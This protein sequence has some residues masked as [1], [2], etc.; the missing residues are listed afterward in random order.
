MR[1][2]ERKLASAMTSLWLD[3]PFFASLTARLPLKA[4]PS[5]TDTMATDAAYIYYAPRFVEDADEAELAGVLAHEGLHVGNGHCHRRN[6]REQELWGEACDYA[7]NALLR[8]AGV[9]LPADGLHDP[10]FEGMAAEEIYRALRDR[11]MQEQEQQQQ[12]DEQQ[13]SQQESNDAGQ[14]A[15]PPGGDDDGAEGD[16]QSDADVAGGGAGDDAEGG[17]DGADQGDAQGKGEGE[18][19]GEGEGEGAGEG[20][21]LSAAPRHTGRAGGVLDAT[22]DA[23]S[24]GECVEALAMAAVVTQGRGKMPAGAD[25][26]LAEA[27]RARMDW[28]AETRRFLTTLRPTDYAWARPNAR[29]AAQRLYLPGLREQR[30]GHL[31]LAVDTSGSTG[32]WWAQFIAEVAQIVNELQPDRVTLLQCD[33]AVSDVRT[34]ERGEELSADGFAIKGGGGTSFVPIFEYVERETLLP[35]A[36]ILLTDTDGDW[37]EREPEYPV[38]VASVSASGTAPFGEVIY[39][40]G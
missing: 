39:M 33:A 17:G 16:G 32:Y 13:D 2:A 34:F 1:T 14:S 5:V 31:V 10:E 15:E 9:R 11:R 26:M 35:D 28:R 3:H 30:L 22:A 7:I 8:R 38:L 36:L 6:G 27:L 23:P 40:E 4:A 20:D 37:P 24:E 19:A 29:Y 21:A 18:G 12:D 25:A